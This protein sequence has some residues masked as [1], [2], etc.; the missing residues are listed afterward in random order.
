MLQG[1]ESTVYRPRVQPGRL[2]SPYTE[3]FLAEILMYGHQ[4]HLYMHN[5]Y[6]GAA[7]TAKVAGLCR[8]R[9]KNS[10]PAGTDATSLQ[11]LEQQHGFG[12]GL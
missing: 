11:V 5:F 4:K 3:V 1:A 10:D 12:K 9:L 6:R 8:H 7:T 2:E